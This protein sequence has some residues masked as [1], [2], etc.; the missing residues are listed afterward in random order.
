MTVLVAYLLV[1][2]LQGLS[3]VDELCNDGGYVSNKNYL[4]GTNVTKFCYPNNEQDVISLV[5]YAYNNSETTTI[6]ATGAQISYSG[7]AQMES[8]AYDYNNKQYD[9]S[10]PKETLLLNLTNMKSIVDVNILEKQLT[11]E[12]GYNVYE[13]VQLIEIYNWSFPILRL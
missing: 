4:Y 10:K 12:T 7:N 9:K 3:I 1:Q 6:R 11:I 5:T 13:L 8:Y 2:M